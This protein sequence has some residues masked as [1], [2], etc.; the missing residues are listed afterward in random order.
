M[1]APSLVDASGAKR[2]V[3]IWFAV[4][5]GI[6]AWLAHLVFLSSFTA[7]ACHARGS[8]WWMHAATVGLAAVT[9]TAMALSLALV[10]GNRSAGPDDQGQPS[11]LR[12]L[13]VAGVLIGAINLALILFEGFYVLVLPRCG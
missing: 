7:Y 4:F 6:G 2:A 13:G 11:Q 10:R 1:S 9:L 5:G 3:R 8:T 12:F